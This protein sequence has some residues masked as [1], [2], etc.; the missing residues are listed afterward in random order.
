MVVTLPSLLPGISR[1]FTQGMKITRH[2]SATDHLRHVI[3]ESAQTLY[4]LRVLRHHGM[5]EAG[6]QLS[7][8]QSSWRGWHTHHHQH[9][10]RQRAHAFLQQSKRSGFCQ[11]DLPEFDQL[12]E[13]RDDELFSKIKNNPN[14]S[15]QQLLPAQSMASQLYVYDLRDRTQGQ[16]QAHQRHLLDCNLITRMLYKDIYWI[17]TYVHCVYNIIHCML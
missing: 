7:S 15:L 9:T 8:T 10:D 13:E 12:M 16:L 17:F 11:P 2:L 1:K 3:S 4:A 6:L 5:T 14:H